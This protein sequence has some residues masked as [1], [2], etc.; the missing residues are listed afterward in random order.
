MRNAFYPSKPCINKTDSNLAHMNPEVLD[1]KYAADLLDR[2]EALQSEAAA[3]LEDLNL[4]AVLSRIGTPQQIGSCASGLMVWR[5]IDC[6]V[7]SPSLSI[8]DAFETVRLLAAHPRISKVRY[9]NERGRFNPTGEP[10]DERYYLALFYAPD[11]GEEWK[12][13]ISFWLNDLPRSE[14]EDLEKMQ[15]QLSSESRL[16]RRSQPRCRRPSLVHW[17]TTQYRLFPSP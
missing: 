15:K 2:Q 6:N 9:M 10:R 13:D 1:P 11:R 16:A 17:A 3:V 14:I 5:D 12:I 7:V 4:L 8:N